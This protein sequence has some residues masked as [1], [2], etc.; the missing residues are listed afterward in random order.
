MPL[1]RSTPAGPSNSNGT[2][3]PASTVPRG[4]RAPPPA[5]TSEAGPSRPKKNRT[6]KTES[7]SNKENPPQARP[8][9]AAKTNGLRTLAKLYQD[10]PVD[11]NSNENVDQPYQGATGGASDDDDDDENDAA[12]GDESYSEEAESDVGV[13]PK[14]QKTSK[15][16]VAVAAGTTPSHPAPTVPS[17]KAS[18]SNKISSKAR[19]DPKVKKVKGKEKV[20]IAEG[21]ENVMVVDQEGSED[22]AGTEDDDAVDSGMDWMPNLPSTIE[23][24]ML[25]RPPRSRS[26]LARHDLHRPLTQILR[27]GPLSA[28]KRPSNQEMD[29]ESDMG[30]SGRNV[31]ESSVGSFIV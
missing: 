9:R 28:Y 23:P 10:Y 19:T 15:G 8:S 12:V 7:Q 26:I 1:A 3:L 25:E 20:N 29:H 14:R 18:T 2:V 11:D 4:I 5:T 30:E 21:D 31:E 22:D 13:P 27:T 24:S 16:T 6:K 17:S